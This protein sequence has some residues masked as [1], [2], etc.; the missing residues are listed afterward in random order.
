M[1]G[2]SVHRSFSEDNKTLFQTQKSW[3]LD[4]VMI[5]IN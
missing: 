1:V 5:E 2:I 3:E 4:G